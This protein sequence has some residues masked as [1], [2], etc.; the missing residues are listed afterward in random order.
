MVMRSD[1]PSR[2]TIAVLCVYCVTSA[3]PTLP[4]QSSLRTL[5]DNC[6]PD[7]W[8]DEFIYYLLQKCPVNFQISHYFELQ[9]IAY[10]SY[11]AKALLPLHS[12]IQIQV[13]LFYPSKN[14]H[15]NQYDDLRAGVA[16][17]KYQLVERTAILGMCD[18]QI[19]HHVQQDEMS[20]TRY[21]RYRES[22]CPNNYTWE[23]FR[24]HVQGIC[25]SEWHSERSNSLILKPKTNELPRPASVPADASARFISPVQD[26]PQLEYQCQIEDI[27]LVYINEHYRLRKKFDAGSHGEIWRATNTTHGV[28]HTF[29]LKRLFLEA[30]E[31]MVRMGL[32]EAYYGNLLR[33]E[34]YIARF[35]EHF[36]RFPPSGVS[37]NDAT[38]NS[39]ADTFDIKIYSS[40]LE[41]EEKPF[42][43]SKELWLVFQ[44]EGISLRHY[45]YSKIPTTSS[46]MYESSPLWKR[47]RQDAEGEAVL[48]EIML[49]LLKG[50]AILHARG[51]THR[52][53]K[54]SNILISVPKHTAKKNHSLK[55]EESI[56]VRLADFGSAVDAYTI[57]EFYN[58][59]PTQAEETREY[60]P[61]EVLFSELGIVYDYENPMSYDLWS[62]GIIF[63]ELILGSPQVFLIS[64]RE[65]VKLDAKLRGKDEQTK[66]KSYLLHVITDEFCIFQPDLTPQS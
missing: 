42:L 54:P 34:P 26:G 1:I 7:T 29:I 33:G 22:V 12:S 46:V 17:Q 37:K 60:Q 51:I 25:V 58:G 32:R 23:A 64:A 30:G 28:E 27:H 9:T 10:Q 57:H 49:Q 65:R 48:K 31:G 66:L 19:F 11:L 45:I 38:S 4:I 47:L 13:P 15:R 41:N 39:N 40:R 5:N 61:P 24:H 18:H 55:I 2:A 14:A 62:T 3:L 56:V 53:L 35:V 16:I 43:Q 8:N 59:K 50:I 44:D 21:R 63:L 20:L 52:D 36:F 6:S